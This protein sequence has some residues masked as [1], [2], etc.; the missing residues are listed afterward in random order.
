MQTSI[1]LSNSTRPWLYE[2]S[3]K[4]GRRAYGVEFDRNN[5][6]ENYLNDWIVEDVIGSPLDITEYI[7]NPEL[8]SDDDILNL[9]TELKMRGMKL[10]LDFVPNHLAPDCELVYTDPG[11]FILAPEGMVDEEIYSSRGIAFGSDI[12]HHS[13]EDVIQLNYLKKNNRTNERKF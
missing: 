11:N 8:G 6:Y 2:L 12:S 7:C 3:K 13:R 10:I 4:Y 5:T 9:R 1:S